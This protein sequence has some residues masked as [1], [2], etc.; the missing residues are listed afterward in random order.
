MN[1]LCRPLFAWVM[2]AALAGTTSAETLELV[3][4]AGK[5]L[6]IEILVQGKSLTSSWDAF[7][8]HWF[9]YLD[10]DGDGVL[11]REEAARSFPLPLQG[12]N[13]VP[14]DFAHAAVDGKITRA[15]L[16]AYYRRAGFTPVLALAEPVSVTNLHLADALFR[17]LGPGR[18]GRLTLDHF[19]RAPRLL[20][21][22]DE[23]DDEILT[24]A[25]I[26]SLGVRSDLRVPDRCAFE[27]K[28][29]Q[30]RAVPSS[31][32]LFLENGAFRLEVVQKGLEFAGGV[33]KETRRVRHADAILTFSLPENAA[34]K[35]VTVSRQFVLA[36][37]ELA[38]GGVDKVHK[39]K[40][41][42]NPVLQLLADLFPYADRDRDGT[43]TRAE[44]EWFVDLIA[45]GASCQLL[46]RLTDHGR[47]LFHH[48]DADGDGRL[49]PRE[50]NTAWRRVAALGVGDGWT[51]DEV[52]HC[53]HITLQRGFA[54]TSFGPL[55]LAALPRGPRAASPTGRAKAGPAWFQ[56]MDRNGDGFVSR[57]EFLGP[58]ELFARLDRDGDGLLNA[59]EAEQADAP[60]KKKDAGEREPAF[61]PE[62]GSPQEIPDLLAYWKLDEG[63]GTSAV[64]ASK[65]ALKATLRG[66]RWV[67][68][69]KGKALQFDNK[70][71][72]L[73][74][75]S[76]QGLNF[77]GGDPFTFAGWVRTT[78]L[79]G[80]VMSQRNAKDGGANID[81]TLNGGKLSALVRE[82]GRELGQHATITGA[83]VNDGEWH[84]FAFTRKDRTIELF[85]DGVS[86]GKAT[87]QDAGGPITTDLRALGAELIWARNGISTPY[88]RA[89]VDE[90]CVFKRALGA[91]EIRKLAGPPRPQP[92][93]QGMRP[94]ELGLKQGK[95]S[96]KAKITP[97]DDFD[98]V[99]TK[100]RCKVYTVR[101]AA[102]K[103][104]Q[105]DMMSN[106]LDAYLRLEDANGKELARD[107][108]SGDDLNARIVFPCPA[109]GTYRII[110][111]TYYFENGP[112]TLSVKEK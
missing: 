22:L 94:I 88:L 86:Q 96:V 1:V 81:L 78:A 107:D 84:H 57:R 49:D 71:D 52:P 35:S 70:G 112:F 16:K 25:E 98:T 58:P 39:S 23:D 73:D 5:R 66:G 56:A 43:L 46:V 45:E 75:G 63:E 85:I 12:Q 30:D 31:L 21:K 97:A 87:G 27:W 95:V 102:G 42:N 2:L 74:Y 61:K 62:P 92:V 18:D 11:S 103:T 80:P 77:K 64:D 40:V 89:T 68:G 33:G 50:L 110:A 19:K 67:P 13:A 54:G 76:D 26:L 93:A 24:P 99:R 65:H 60:D 41:E 104:Y 47:N 82:D 10:L 106:V 4:P 6:G 111:T 53:A 69:I 100:R 38:G 9:D 32:K 44:L 108:D 17:H 55:P 29:A 72:Y 59:N 90:F 101:L 15:G 83:T 109:A 34:S 3:T 20:R 91:D 7:L 79:Q 48:L 105:I 8:D 36:Q 51:K 14:L 28:T 37:F